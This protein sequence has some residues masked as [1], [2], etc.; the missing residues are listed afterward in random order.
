MEDIKE[1]TSLKAALTEAERER[2]SLDRE[3]PDYE[4]NR[5]QADNNVDHLRQRIASLN[6]AIR[7]SS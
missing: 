1:L 5:L 3:H 7:Q 6:R 2:A 4:R